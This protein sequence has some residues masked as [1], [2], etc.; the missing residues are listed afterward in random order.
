[1][2]SVH[3]KNVTPTQD[4]LDT[5]KSVEWDT[6]PP[7]TPS[8]PSCFPGPSTSTSV[9]TPVQTRY[10]SPHVGECFRLVKDPRTR[11]AQHWCRA[12]R[13]DSDSRRGRDRHGGEGRLGSWGRVRGGRVLR[14]VCG[15]HVRGLNSLDDGEESWVCAR[16]RTRWTRW[17]PGDGLDGSQDLRER[18]DAWGVG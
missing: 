5:Q 18:R 13:G 9:P 12:R 17:G 4:T 2:T 16:I 10:S 1:M 15:H 8:L 3:L 14:S 7:T 6:N 11:D